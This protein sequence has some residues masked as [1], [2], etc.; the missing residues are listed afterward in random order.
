MKNLPSAKQV[1]NWKTPGRHAV[2]FGCYLQ[3]S[4]EGGRSWIFRYQANGRARHVGLGS[5]VEVTLAEARD[6]ALE[7]RRALRE[8]G[9][10]PL[11]SRAA[12][13]AKVALD[14]AKGVTFR[15]CAERYIAAHEAGW[16]SPIHRR[17]WS[18]TLA[19]YVYPTFG[20]LP[21]ATID[22][23]LVTRALEPVWNDKPE[24]ASRVRGRIES[25]LDWAKARG[26][27][28]GEN[29]ARWKGH[30]DNLFPARS[31]VVQNGPP[32]GPALH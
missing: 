13:R 15:E 28:D 16:R 32:R 4:G 19:Q 31:K 17:Q 23:A 7:Y 26:Y 12:A 2:G 20:N 6:R 5:V 22:T 21:V 1:D 9:T 25:I 11:V 10:D 27:R 29:P 14:A 18:N 30:L 24:T 3:I 8:D